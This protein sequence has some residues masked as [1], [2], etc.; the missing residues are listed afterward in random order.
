[1]LIGTGLGLAISRH[2]AEMMGGQVWVQSQEGVGSIFH[3]TIRVPCS[4]DHQPLYLSP[5][6]PALTDKLVWVLDENATI[7]EQLRLMMNHWGMRVVT[8]ATKEEFMTQLVKCSDHEKSSSSTTTT[9]RAPGDRPSVSLISFGSLGHDSKSS[10][11]SPESHSPPATGSST[12]VLTS[13][14]SSS[15]HL[16]SLSSSSFAQST[17]DAMQLLRAVRA[18]YTKQELALVLMCPLNDRSQQAKALVNAFGSKPVK[19]RQLLKSLMTVFADNERNAGNSSTG[20]STQEGST[21]SNDTLLRL[22]PLH[23]ISSDS[24]STERADMKEIDSPLASPLPSPPTSSSALTRSSL[25]LSVSSTP[26]SRHSKDVAATK[27]PLRPLN[28]LV[29]EDNL[30]NQ[31]VIRQMLKLQVSDSIFHP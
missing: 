25:S 8:F 26:S 6:Q 22:Q 15:S 4:F 5:S 24:L 16:S 28:I 20:T 13:S 19:P 29:V 17:M 18:R 14:M 11:D 10:G 7:R 1:V 31:K 9:T 2:F 21:T 27:R 3:F 23:S 12:T 30:V